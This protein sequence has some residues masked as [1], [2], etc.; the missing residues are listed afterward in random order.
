MTQ[1]NVDKCKIL[2][3]VW[4]MISPNMTNLK[5]LNAAFEQGFPYCIIIDLVILTTRKDTP[6]CRV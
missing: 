3:A 5:L 6:L 4:Y 2:L 1:H